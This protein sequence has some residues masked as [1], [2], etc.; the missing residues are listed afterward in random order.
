MCDM[1]D[2]K[3]TPSLSFSEAISNA[4]GKI[5]QFHGRARRSE[6]WWTGFVDIPHVQPVRV[7]KIYSPTTPSRFASLRVNHFKPEGL[8]NNIFIWNLTACRRTGKVYQVADWC[9]FDSA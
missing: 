4:A 3:E 2:I 5:L 9:H 6:Y 1:E 7:E 8:Y